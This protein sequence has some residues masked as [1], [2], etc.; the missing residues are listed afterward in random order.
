MHGDAA[1][2][3]CGSY[4]YVCSIIWSSQSPSWQ[5]NK[6]IGFVFEGRDFSLLAV[7]YGEVRGR[8]SFVVCDKLMLIIR[9][10]ASGVVFD[11]LL[12]NYIIEF[13]VIRKLFF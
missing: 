12:K 11:D 10:A 7:S 5:V 6:Y 4:S 1:G 3:G 9:V 13:I 2:E 8:I